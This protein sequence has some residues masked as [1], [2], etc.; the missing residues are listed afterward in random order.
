MPAERVAMRL[1]RE[2]IQLKISPSLPTRGIARRLCLAPSTIWGSLKHAKFKARLNR[3]SSLDTARQAPCMSLISAIRFAFLCGCR[4]SALRQLLERLTGFIQNGFLPGQLCVPANLRVDEKRIEF[5]TPAP[6]A[7]FLACYQRRS[8]SAERVENRLAS[9][10]Q[11]DQCVLQHCDG[12]DHGMV[13]EAAPR[14]RSR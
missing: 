6:A 13:R 7:G 10:R 9:I 5:R 14:V 3:I 4:R 11:I 2:I 12:F 1:A 8:G